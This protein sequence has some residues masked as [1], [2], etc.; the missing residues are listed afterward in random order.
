[1]EKYKRIVI[2][3]VFLLIAL[4]TIL[5]SGINKKNKNNNLI[6][7]Y[8][9]NTNSINSTNKIAPMNEIIVTNEQE[10]SVKQTYLDTIRNS[11]VINKQKMDDYKINQITVLSDGE[12]NKVIDMYNDYYKETDTLVYVTYSVKPNDLDD[13][14]LNIG[15]GVQNGN[16]ITYENVCVCIRDGKVI[17]SGTSW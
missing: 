1:M 10:K 4:I 7:E 12:K 6:S 9:S 5:I 13:A 14:L 16:W 2:I 11:Q 17:S 8:N 3:I 15:T